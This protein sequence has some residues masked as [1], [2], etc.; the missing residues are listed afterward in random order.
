MGAEAWRDARGQR[1]FQPASASVSVHLPWGQHGTLALELGTAVGPAG[2]PDGSAPGLAH[3]GGAVVGPWWLQRVLQGPQLGTQT[4][5]KGCL[6]A[7]ADPCLCRPQWERDWVGT[8][9][10]LAS[11]WISASMPPAQALEQE[12]RQGL[13]LHSGL[14]PLKSPGISGTD[15]GATRQTLFPSALW[16]LVCTQMHRGVTLQSLTHTLGQGELSHSGSDEPGPSQGPR[17]PQGPR[18]KHDAPPVTD[19][20]RAPWHLGCKRICCGW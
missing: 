10:E 14:C 15:A 8:D 20:G 5:G 11:S 13:C 17:E 1:S 3:C 19:L 18:Q 12:A 4:P 7:A 6:R 16:A 2:P 9:P